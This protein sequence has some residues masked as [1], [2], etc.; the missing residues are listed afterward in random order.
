MLVRVSQSLK[1][2]QM[3]AM[4]HLPTF[5]A[6]LPW[7]LLP[8]SRFVAFT[9]FDTVMLL[10]SACT[11]LRLPPVRPEMKWR[12]FWFFVDAV[13]VPNAGLACQA[14]ISAG[15]TWASIPLGISSSH[16]TPRSKAV[17]HAANVGA[18]ADSRRRRRPEPAEFELDCVDFQLGAQTGSHSMK[19]WHILV[20]ESQKLSAR[21]LQPTHGKH[22]VFSSCQVWRF[23]SWYDLVGSYGSYGTWFTVVTVPVLNLNF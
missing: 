21:R 20:D 14:S 19:P 12:T 3:C 23:F 7:L 16:S 9:S 4:C 15:T 17:C 6:H 13:C 11:S 5:C 2:H 8:R 1:N 10:P 22:R 18:Q